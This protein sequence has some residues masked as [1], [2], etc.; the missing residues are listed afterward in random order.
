M[1]FNSIFFT[2]HNRATSSGTFLFVIFE[3]YGE[4]CHNSIIMYKD[5][6]TYIMPFGFQTP[7]SV[8]ELDSTLVI[9]NIG[10]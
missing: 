4:F 10:Y 3:K 7:A 9:S 8:E 6:A 2:V 5:R 1:I